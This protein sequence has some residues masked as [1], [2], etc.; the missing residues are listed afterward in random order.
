MSQTLASLYATIANA[1]TPLVSEPAPALAQPAENKPSRF[2]VVRPHAAGGLGQVSVALDNELCRHVALKEIHPRLADHPESR[3]RFLLEAEVT[4]SLEH[5]GVVP[6]YSLGQWPDGRPYYAMRLIRGD[7]LEDAVQK[8]H[9]G[10]ED[11]AARELGLRKLLR[12]FIDV[13][14]AVD[15]AHSRGVLHRDIKPS[16][17]MLGAYGETLVVDWGL[18]KMGA[19]REAPIHA[20]EVSLGPLTSGNTPATRIGS[21]VGTPAYMSPEQAAG[22]LDQLGPASDVY[23][24]GA[25]LYTVL[26]N[27][28]PFVGD[29]FF[30]VRGLIL[31]GAFPPSHVVCADVPRALEAICRKAMALAPADRYSSARALAE[32]IEK[33]LGDAPV[34]A[35]RESRV[36]LVAR[37][38]RRHRT[39]ARAAAASLLLVTMVALAASW[40]VNRARLQTDEA[41]QQ[42][43]LAQIDLLCNAEPAAIPVILENLRPFH[44]EVIPRL[45][46]L[47]ARS[48]LRPH[49][50]LRLDLALL[51]DEPNLLTDLVDALLVC[52]HDDFPVLRDRLR[53]R[54]AEIADRLWQT[55]QDDRAD[56]SARFRAG[57]ALA[58]YLP[59]SVRWTAA[60]SAFI[61]N[62]LLAKGIDRQRELRIDLQPIAPR[63]LDEIYRSFRDPVKPSDVRVAATAALAAWGGDQPRLLAA[64]VSEAT[65]DQFNVLL[66]P[67]AA[68]EDCATAIAALREIVARQPPAGRAVAEEQRIE[69]GR[70]RAGA[71]IALVRLGSD[72]KFA[73]LFA[74]ADDPESRTQFIAGLRARGV[75]PAELLACL[76][77]A[78]DE[79]VRFGLILSLGEFSL[80]EIPEHRRDGLA[81]QVTT[82]YRTD[83]CS[84]IHGACGWLLRAWQLADRVHDFDRTPHSADYDPMREWF[85][86][87]VGR[88]VALGMAMTMVSFPP[89]EFMMG[90]PPTERDRQNQ[91]AQ[92]R[93]R[94]TRPFVMDD[95]LVSRALYTRFLAD[96]RGSAA[97]QAYLA[98]VDEM[99]PTELHPAVGLNWYDAV[100]FARWLTAETGMSESD[101][102][103]ADPATLALDAHGHPVDRQ[104][105]FYPERKGFRLP[106]EAEWEYACRSGTV[107]T[108]SFGSDQTLACDYGWFQGNSAGSLHQSSPLK[109]TGRGLVSMHGNSAEWCHDWLGFIPGGTGVDPLG[110]A[111]GPC[112]A[113]RSGSYL[114][115]VALSRSACRSGLPPEFS[116][117]YGGMRVVR[118]LA[119]DR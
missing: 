15:Y 113:V 40:I 92:H 118:T 31:Q 21:A 4:G 82:W 77:V 27:R 26:S 6:V 112:R 45:R 34:S 99:A 2:E 55:L 108:F 17:I 1:A 47:R 72:P 28:P 53:P 8:F 79:T 48:D 87:Q 46:S 89:G 93:V 30:V 75:A 73:E 59:D 83:P 12:R 49:E 58:N 101:Q 80:D 60:E 106:T 117:P 7:S 110:A 68:A 10:P 11:A 13:C 25:T 98:T 51:D 54:C 96:S 107:T 16:N 18:A 67:L 32:E 114:S 70:K 39:W 109:P 86:V 20:P 65:A 36:E 88:P 64:A 3:A 44:D 38:T 81:S 14:N 41:H 71:A 78:T 111:D 9:A 63:L 84:A 74:P 33:W 24:L 94:V 100:L 69:L 115:G 90:S 50:R 95:R 97:A 52:G 5:P 76:D 116:A 23:S 105:P 119:E 61:A 37:W 29:D 91:E 22:A 56:S 43:A 103:Y 19:R 62:T 57:L 102:C 104:W 35:Y 42:R 85:L 66:P